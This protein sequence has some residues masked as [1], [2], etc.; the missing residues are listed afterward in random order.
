MGLEE[1]PHC[2]FDVVEACRTGDLDTGSG[3]RG[4]RFRLPPGRS[5][6]A[7][8]MAVAAAV[9]RED[10][11]RSVVAAA[12]VVVL[13]RKRWIRME[14]MMGVESD[15]HGPA[16]GRRGRY[17]R[18]KIGSYEVEGELDGTLGPREICGGGGLWRTDNDGMDDG[19]RTASTPAAE[20][21]TVVGDGG[22]EEIGSGSGGDSGGAAEEMDQEGSGGGGLSDR[23]L[24]AGWATKT[25]TIRQKKNWK[26]RSGRGVG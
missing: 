12:G 7:T 21:G 14:L 17:A 11:K 15:R 2:P 13:L 19:G 9:G 6:T 24:P 3:D 23:V 25:R 22:A 18:R 8:L 4:T 16:T 20:T 5:Q 10:S 1:S 26:L